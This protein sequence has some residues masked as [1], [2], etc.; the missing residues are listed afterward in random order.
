MIEVLFE[1]VHGS[2]LYGL[3]H[4]GS[5]TD[6]FRVLSDNPTIKGKYAKQ[7]TDGTLDTLVCDLQTFMMYAGNGKHQ[8]LEAMYSQQPTIDK[9]PNLRAS[10]HP[11]PY[12]VEESYRHTIRHFYETP[13]LKPLRH[14][15]R[16]L[17]N[18]LDFRE[19]GRFNPTL[20][21][22]HLE[23]LQQYLYDYIDPLT[24]LE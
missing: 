14:S 1:T 12:T 19:F 6:I 8:F 10:F 16:L 18:L 20:D 7:R 11:N 21:E 2:T 4:K 23:R 13:G 9:I 17:M 15:Y 22:A 5:D 3:N 24:Y